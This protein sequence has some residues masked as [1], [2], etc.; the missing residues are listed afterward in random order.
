MSDHPDI[1]TDGSREDFSSIGGFEVA[2]AGVYL[3]ASELAFDCS[4]WGVAEE[5]GD[6]RLER[7][8]ALLPVP[9]PLQTFQRAEFWGAIVAMQ[10]YS[11][12]RLGID[13][14]KVARTLGRLLDR[15]SLVQTLP[16]VKDGDLIALAQHMIRTRGWET[17]RATE[18]KGH[19]EDVDFQQGRVRLLE[20][21][22]GNT[23]A[24]DLGRRHQTEVLIDSWRRLLK[25]VARVTV[26]HDGRGGTAPDPLVW[27]QGGRPK[28]RK[29]AIRVN[30]DLVSLPRPPGF[31]TFLVLTLLPGRTVLVSCVV[32]PPSLVPC[33]GQRVL[34]TW[35]TLEFLLE[36]LILFEQWA[37][38]RLLREKG[39]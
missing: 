27:D 28:A 12:C 17:V 11:P 2:G 38:H 35:A 22:V 9:G 16:L 5:H 36:L 29:L 18:V 31:F 34:M 30:V 4:V 20:D 26:N 6:A 3:P 10:A 21:Q 33:I 14:L 7:C 15:D 39:G 13:N 37:G 32:L 24:A 23:E 25:A 1:W 8:R 19:A